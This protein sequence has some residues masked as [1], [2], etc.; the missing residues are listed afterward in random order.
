[1]LMKVS[2]SRIILLLIVQEIQKQVQ[3]DGKCR[4][5][6]SRHADEG[7]HLPDNIAIHCT[8]DTETSQDDGK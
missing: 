3:G 7:Q 1:M 2:I 5:T 6:Q 4:L 8:G